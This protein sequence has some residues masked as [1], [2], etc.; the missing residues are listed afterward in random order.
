MEEGKLLKYNLF[1]MSLRVDYYR[2]CN[3]KVVVDVLGMVIF[4]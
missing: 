2:V 4:F 1:L 3:I